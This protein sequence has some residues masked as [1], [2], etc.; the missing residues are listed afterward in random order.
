[1][2]PVFTLQEYI[3]A[4]VDQNITIKPGAFKT[5]RY[6]SEEF[7]SMPFDNSLVFVLETNAKLHG[8]ADQRAFFFKMEELGLDVPVIVKRS[9]AFESGKSGSRKVRLISHLISQIS[10]LNYN[11]RRYRFG[12]FI[13]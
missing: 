4:D 2:S 3:L 8:M 12:R 1:L 13:G 9:Y 7:G 5:R 6:R 10:H 11:L